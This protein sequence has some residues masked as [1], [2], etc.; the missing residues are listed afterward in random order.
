MNELAKHLSTR[1]AADLQMGPWLPNPP[2][3][4]AAISTHQH[5]LFSKTAAV[6][7]HIAHAVV[8]HLLQPLACRAQA[9]VYIVIWDCLRFSLAGAP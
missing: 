3:A 1:Q 6:I 7:T 5:R 8:A 9:S 4:A 2:V